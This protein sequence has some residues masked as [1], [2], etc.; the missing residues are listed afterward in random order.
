MSWINRIYNWVTDRN[1]GVPITASRMDAEFDNIISGM[2]TLHSSF[3]TAEWIL[4]SNTPTWVAATQ[5]KFVGVNLAA[6]YH[7]GRRLKIVHNSGATT[8]Y[9]TVTAVAFVTDTTITVSTDDVSSLVSTVTAVSYGVVSYVSPSYLDPRSKVLA[10]RATDPQAITGG[11]G[12]TKV[13]LTSE[14]V[15]ALSE[16]STITST[17]TAKKPGFYLIH[18][19][20][21]FQQQA[22]ADPGVFIWL[23]KNAGGLANSRLNVAGASF[24][25]GSYITQE[26]TWL[27]NLAAGDTIEL[28][29]SSLNNGDIINSGIGDVTSLSIARII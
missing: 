11:G 12:D 23:Y 3:A 5:F 26:V 2:N 14:A 29:F 9:A 4:D 27:G 1:N 10:Y 17:F 16:Y 8:V 7:V 25:T 24:D 22:T 28:Y 19:R 20:V 18:G 15:D 6:T 13:V 21:L